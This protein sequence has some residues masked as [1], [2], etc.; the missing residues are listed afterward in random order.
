MKTFKEH[1]L[2]K[3]KV[4]KFS[5]TEIPTYQ[6]YFNLLD[7]YCM[8]TMKGFLDLCT[9][10]DC[11]PDFLPKYENDESKY[12]YKITPIYSNN[13]IC[14]IR[15]TAYDFTLE[16]QFSYDIRINGME[17][18]EVDFMADEYIEKTVNYIKEHIK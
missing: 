14:I 12:I 7:R 17:D 4:T 3:L 2:E 9:I 8:R 5:G 1:I 11:N 10:Y 6:E 13:H 15:L 16:K 18:K